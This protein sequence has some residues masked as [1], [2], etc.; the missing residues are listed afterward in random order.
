MRAVTLAKK[1][2]DKDLYMKCDSTCPNPDKTMNCKLLYHYNYILHKD[3]KAETL[4]N[5]TVIDAKKNSFDTCSSIKSSFENCW[6]RSDYGNQMFD[7]MFKC[8]I[9]NIF[10]DNKNNEWSVKC[11][12]QDYNS[13]HFND[14][15]EPLIQ[16]NNT[17]NELNPFKIV[18]YEL[19]NDYLLQK[20]ILDEYKGMIVLGIVVLIMILL[21]VFIFIKLRKIIR[22][23]QERVQ[24]KDWVINPLFY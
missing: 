15:N 7:D 17:N 3:Y 23:E 24:S 8:E 4:E 22:K 12:E 9:K 6:S 10:S 20:S 19:T 14:Y 16:C 1:I 13:F 2:V 18:T 21:F 5:T 11:F